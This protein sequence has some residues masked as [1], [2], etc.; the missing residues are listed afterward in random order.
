MSTL[1]PIQ[2]HEAVR[3]AL[4]RAIERN[5]L[6]GSLLIHGPP[7]VA[8]Q[9]LALWLAQRL[10][11]ETPAGPEPCG[12]CAPCRMALRLEHPDVHWFMP[13]PR[14]KGASSPDKLAD[15]L[16]EARAAELAQRRDNPLRPV[17]PGEPV[18][19]FLAQVQ[20]IR[21][22]ATARPAMGR[23]KVF[24][25][26]DAEA[27]VPQESSPEA[28]NALLKV[29]EEP[30]PDTTF[31]LTASDPDALLPTIRS[32]LL[33]VR[34]RALPEDD[35]AAFLVEYRGVT[36]EQAA[37]A[38]RLAQGSIGQALAFLPAGDEPGPLEALRI[39]AREMLEAAGARNPLQRLALAHATSPAGAR[40]A[41]SDT[42]DMLSLWLRDLAA[43]ANGAEEHVVNIDAVDFLR[44]LA[45]RLPHTAST[46]PDALRAVEEA[47]ALAQGNVNPQLIIARLLTALHSILSGKSLVRRLA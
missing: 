28:A 45:Q 34:L 11:C 38:A 43:V 16:E 20:T 2:G 29:L 30:P 46:I 8:K 14:P 35:V 7:G 33:P 3:A 32:R 22:M 4:G 19:L 27:L 10:V 21:R 15:A 9:R 12:R 42:L 17:A 44:A 41:F 6:P 36:P 39:A 23:L 24:L 5:E 31:I 1:P 37:L 13:L 18:G 26:G 47:S 25:I 40:G